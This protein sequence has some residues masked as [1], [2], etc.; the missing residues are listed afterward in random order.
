[1]CV[2]LTRLGLAEQSV[3]AAT[4]NGESLLWY[5]RR[6]D[7]HQL[8]HA[9]KAWYVLQATFKA[10]GADAHHCT[11]A[12]AAGT[13]GGAASVRPGTAPASVSG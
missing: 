13:A 6:S 7:K 9:R 11:S 2:H 3:A 10:I 8:E 1:M 5:D 12:V 4:A